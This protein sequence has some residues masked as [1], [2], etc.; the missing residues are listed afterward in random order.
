MKILVR[1]LKWLLIVVIS[2]Y[3]G[4]QIYQPF[5]NRRLLKSHLNLKDLP[6]V[7]ATECSD[8]GFTDVLVKCYFEISATDY[9]L[10]FAGRTYSKTWLRPDIKPVNCGDV[11]PVIADPFPAGEIRQ[12]DFTDNG[13]PGS[14]T[15]CA[16]KERTKIFTDLYIE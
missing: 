14:F 1:I 7:S 4:C 13:L 12:A 10:L 8:Y 15:I 2:G 11:G 5:E 6:P 3:V 9:P 16:N